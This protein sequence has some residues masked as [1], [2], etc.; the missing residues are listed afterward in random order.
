MSKCEDCGHNRRPRLTVI[1]SD[2]L[3][4]PACHP[5]ATVGSWT[6]RC[7][8]CCEPVA[9]TQHDADADKYACRDCHTSWEGQ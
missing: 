5:D 1:G 3:M 4:C 6:T 9:M 8:V 7:L 2:A